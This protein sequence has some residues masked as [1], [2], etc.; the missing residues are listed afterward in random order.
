M[1]QVFYNLNITLPDANLSGAVSGLLGV[2]PV[3]TSRQWRYTLLETK[4]NF[5]DFMTVFLDLLEGKYLALEQLGVT[6]QDIYFHAEYQ[7]GNQCNAEWEPDRLRRMG[8]NGID[9]S[10]SARWLEDRQMEDAGSRSGL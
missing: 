10:V 6:R 1:I 9:L 5:I 3:D 8:E 7:Y 2:Q 4:D